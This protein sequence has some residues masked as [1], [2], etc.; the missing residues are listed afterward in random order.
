[1]FSQLDGAVDCLQHVWLDQLALAEDADAGAVAVEEGAVLGQ[2]GQL[3]PRHVHQ[4]VDL[5]F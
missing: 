1:M 2:L 3:Y 4:G 5:V